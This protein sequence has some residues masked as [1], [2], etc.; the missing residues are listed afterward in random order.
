[1]DARSDT[2]T[3]LTEQRLSLSRHPQASL[4]TPASS[5]A[6][7]R[8]RF[9]QSDFV[10]DEATLGSRT[11]AQRQINGNPRPLQRRHRQPKSTTSRSTL[12]SQPV[13]VR[14]YSAETDEPAR[15]PTT[16]P[17]RSST[18]ANEEWANHPDP[19]L[20]SIQDFSIEGILRAIEPDI[21]S[22]LDNIAEICG[23]SKLSLANEYGSH[24][25][26]QG[27]IRATGRSMDNGL[28]TV[29]EASPSDEQFIDENVAIMGDNPSLVDGRDHLPTPTLEMLQN[30]QQASNAMGYRMGMASSWGDGSSI[31]AQPDTPG[32]A[33]MTDAGT[34]DAELHLPAT[35]DDFPPKPS[36]ASWALLG[37]NVEPAGNDC[38]QNIVTQPVVSE[39]HLDA[40]A[41]GRSWV[42]DGASFPYQMSHDEP[43]LDG[44]ADAGVPGSDV[45]QT[46][47]D[48]LSILADLQSW[49]AWVKGAAQQMYHEGG[50]QASQSAETTLREVLERQSVR[51]YE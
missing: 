21:R 33:A 2:L 4:R 46:Q 22:T 9:Q 30:L 44:T 32:S 38:P 29:E 47:A 42:A 27:E 43:F 19:G 14:T 51:L 20:P 48:K 24:L 45:P 23:R 31:Q 28:V 50:Y 10:V 5:S 26:P 13:I 40:G 3:H 36:V 35:T 6:A 1:M 18:L 37:R 34:D 15:S 11:I 41:N 16:M 17:S 49:L 39:V 7:P 25:P 8:S 12:A